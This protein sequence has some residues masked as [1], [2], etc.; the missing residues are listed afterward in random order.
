MA[1][2]DFYIFL[3]NLV[4]NKLRKKHSKTVHKSKYEC[5]YVIMNKKT[6]SREQNLRNCLEQTVDVGV[7]KFRSQDMRRDGVFN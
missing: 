7:I 2:T 5:I 1:V 6:I 3:N 4:I